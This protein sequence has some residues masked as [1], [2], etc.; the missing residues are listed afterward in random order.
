MEFVPLGDIKVNSVLLTPK[1]DPLQRQRSRLRLQASDE[2]GTEYN[3]TFKILKSHLSELAKC[4]SSTKE[5]L[6]LR[7]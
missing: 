6:L 4:T 2:H 5:S 1:I 3:V 7:I